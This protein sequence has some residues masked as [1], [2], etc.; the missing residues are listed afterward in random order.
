MS[1][2]G[3][4]PRRG[5]VARLT[6]GLA[7]AVIFAILFV[8]TRATPAFHGTSGTVA[9]VG[10]LLLAGTLA[11]E[12]LDA[13]GV[14]H[15]T[16]YLLAGIL[17]GPHAL[18]L[19]DHAS[20]EELTSVDT[21]A[22]A[23]IAM[24]GGAELDLESVKKGLKSLAFST[25]LQTA[26]LAVGM[27]AAFMAAR[28]L[29]PFARPLGFGALLGAGLLWSVLAMSR[30]PSA[31][32]GILAQ[33]RAQGPLTRWT[34]TFVMSSDVVVVVLLAA[35][36]TV[37]RVLIEPGATLSAKAF[38]ALGHEIVGSVSL[39]T[40]LGLL[41][42]AYLRL[43]AKGLPIVFVALGFGFTEVL[44]Y[45]HFDPL[46][47]FLVAGF[48]VQNLSRQGKTFLHAIERMGGVVYVVFFASAG[49]HL[50][51]PLLA[52]LWPVA[53]LLAGSRAALSY[54]AA[55]L[56]ARVARDDAVVRRWSFAGLVS[57]AGLTLGLS[58][59]IEH[60]FPMLGAGFRALVLAT[61]ALNEMVGPIIFKLALDKAGE[62]RPEERTSVVPAVAEAE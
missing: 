46:L 41:L 11:S 39:G 9:A 31:T 4:S 36:L 3:A 10:F 34:L 59:T 23:L 43:F 12:L 57:Q 54:G 1:R 28:P 40:T 56:S 14:P 37:A 7:L 55:R 30:S 61:V 53:L 47:T 62:S 2:G 25:M 58:A 52:E 35:A 17:A 24:A 21:L 27:V 20:V 13:L 16:G 32:L 38:Q 33:T 45:L 6:Q 50:D 18:R 5:V 49:A 42:A 22:L 19:I 51:L 29:I 26:V 48:V 15:L 60:E 44:R 8:A